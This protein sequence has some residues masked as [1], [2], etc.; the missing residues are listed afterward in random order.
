MQIMATCFLQE[1][2]GACLACLFPDLA[3]DKRHPCPGT[4][5]MSEILQT[6]G[7]LAVYAIDTVVTSRGRNWNYRSVHLADPSLSGA[8]MIAIRDGCQHLAS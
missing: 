6:V 1:R 2:E 7:G 3:E 8:A 5:A 4:P